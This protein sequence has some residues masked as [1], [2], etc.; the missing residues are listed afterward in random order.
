MLTTLQ[1]RVWGTC[2]FAGFI[3]V[4]GNGRNP[5]AS[6]SVWLLMPCIPSAVSRCLYWKPLLCPQPVLTD[7][8]PCASLRL[9]PMYPTLSEFSSCYLCDCSS[10][11]YPGC[12]IY[13][14]MCVCMC[15]CYP[16]IFVYICIAFLHFRR[17][18]LEFKREWELTPFHS[19]LQ[20][21]PWEFWPSASERTL[22]GHY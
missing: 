2:I 4:R 3:F 17:S 22:G 7:V 19:C 18:N 13:A 15:M 20:V 6:V 12:N 16:N 8:C 1:A 9:R 10:F 5:R 21:L 11:C 14:Y